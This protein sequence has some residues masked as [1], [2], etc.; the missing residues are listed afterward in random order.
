MIAHCCRM[1]A[2]IVGRD[3]RE[4]GERALL[5]LGHTFAHALEAATGYSG[6][7]LHGEAVAIGMVLA[8][9]LSERLGYSPAGDTERLTMQLKNAGLPTVVSD[10]DRRPAPERL[11]EF[12]QRDKKT[13]GGKLKFVLV[14]GLG[15]A[16]VSADVPADAVEA[17]V[18]Q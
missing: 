3:E 11:L 4:S 2:E 5:N 9:R 13:E 18:A 7:L 15:K 6:T 10:L 16:F 12:M 14:R 17:V 8:F 1:K